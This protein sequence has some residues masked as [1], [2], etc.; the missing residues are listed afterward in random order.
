MRNAAILACAL[1]ISLSPA[2][3][4]GIC[5]DLVSSKA[6]LITNIPLSQGFAQWQKWLQGGSGVAGV[7]EVKLVAEPTYA[8]VVQFSRTQGGSDGGAA[9]IFQSLAVVDTLRDTIQ[10]DIVGKV[11]DQQGGNI[12]NINPK[13]FPEGAVQVR[14]KYLAKDNQPR[15][16][17]HGFYSGDIAGAE[18]ANFTKVNANTW[19]NYTSP[20]LK[21]LPGGMKKITEIRIYGFGWGFT[22]QVASID[23]YKVTRQWVER[24][25]CK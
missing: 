8:N 7:N 5:R 22:G 25:G 4:K 24:A 3:D 12:A 14:I 18:A 9:G 11:L 19:F 17:Y 16:W 23:L 1:L 10:L 20:N 21:T 2:G 15:E 6:S 13:W